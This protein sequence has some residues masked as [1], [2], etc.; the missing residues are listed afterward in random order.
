MK[1]ID[2]LIEKGYST[3]RLVSSSTWNKESRSFYDMQL[4]KHP[5]AEHYK[6]GILIPFKFNS[7]YIKSNFNALENG[8]L[9]VV[10]KKGDD[11]F[12]YGL[13]DKDKPPILV[14]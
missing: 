1:N 8:G 12:Y 14:K 5:N 9:F 4:R 2:T 6:N 13:R 3:Y 7:L 10:F 11:V